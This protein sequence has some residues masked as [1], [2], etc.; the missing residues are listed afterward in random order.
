MLTQEQKTIYSKDGYV[1]LPNVILR[2]NLEAMISDLN[3]WIEEKISVR[4]Q[5]LEVE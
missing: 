4:N 3:Q 5:S 1:I 2:K